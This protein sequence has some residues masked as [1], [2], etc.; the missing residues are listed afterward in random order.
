MTSARA[1]ID[2][3]EL[4]PHPEGGYFRETYRSPETIARAHLPERFGGDRAF[5]TAIYYLLQA[6]D[7]SAF[8]RIK[9][10]EG[11]HFYDGAPLTVHVLGAGAAYSA[12]KL[13]RDLARG[14]LPQAV[15]RA[16]DLFAA[17]LEGPAGYTLV[18]CTVAPG[19]DFADFEVPPRHELL[20]L[21]PQH[22]ELIQRLTR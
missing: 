9:A 12:I 19:F 3:L 2:H 1:W 17:E 16:G 21:Y 8:H 13:G 10:D 15:V 4:K 14:E 22:K 18:G 6:G 20:A 7:F 11:W 5:S